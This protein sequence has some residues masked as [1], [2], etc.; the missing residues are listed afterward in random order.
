VRV[1]VTG[2]TGFVGGALARRLLELGFELHALV[3]NESAA[4]A[5]AKSGARVHAG[6]LGDPNT[7][8]EAATGCD[9]LFH[10]AGESSVRAPAE[11]HAWINV[12][13]TENA[14][15]AARHADVK[16]FVL[17]SCADVSLL[18]KDRLHWKENAALGQAP[19]GTMA[20]NKLLAEELALH[21]SNA[22]LSVIAIRPAWLWG[23]GDHTNL[24]ALCREAGAGGVRLFGD[25]HN[26]FSTTYI[27]NLVDALIAAASAKG[28]D[29]QAFH[30][31]DSDVLTAGEFFGR[32]CAALGMAAPRRGIYALAYAAAVVRERAGLRGVWPEEVVRRG[33]GTLL[34]GL[35]AHQFLA[36]QPRT[37]VDAGMLALTAWATQLGGPDAIAKLAR[38]VAGAAD[39]AHHRQLASHPE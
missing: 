9:A 1:L 18:N 36:Y 17:L 39:V 33:R 37:S 24:P 35:R 38:S 20:R 2:A 7:I 16:R 23:P 3:R 21:A 5:L 19:L 14:L 28:A 15:L 25:G 27:D 8:A 22:R 26:L 34:D 32:L 10:C 12:A 29:G 6:N 4:E 30:V 31:A 13:G 11:A